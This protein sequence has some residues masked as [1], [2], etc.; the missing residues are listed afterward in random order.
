MPNWATTMI[1]ITGKKKDVSEFLERIKGHNGKEVIDFEAII[2]SPKTKE[3]Y[4]KMGLKPLSEDDHIQ[5]EPDRPWFNWW[6]F[7]N[8]YWGTKWNA[9]HSEYHG[10]LDGLADDQETQVYILFDTAWSPPGPILDKICNE[11]SSKLDLTIKM[12]E[13]QGIYGDIICTH[14]GKITRN[15][16]YED[17][18]E[19]WDISEEVI[20]YSTRSYNEE[21]YSLNAQST[22]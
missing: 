21:Q 9:S 15:D 22:K 19:A 3:E 5:S 14:H 8:R 1:E 20:G 4:I 17:C 11:M 18:D 10:S 12:A 6:E 16:S 7:C 2:P 13:E